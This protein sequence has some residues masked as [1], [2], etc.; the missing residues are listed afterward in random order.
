M[1]LTEKYL[2]IIALV[3]AVLIAF[4]GINPDALRILITTVSI[5]EIKAYI[6]SFGIFAPIVFILLQILQ[7]VVAP[8]PGAI[9]VIAGGLIWGTILG[10]LLSIIGAFTG[11][12]I[13][14]A[15]SRILGRP[16]IEKIMRKEDIQFVDNFF[17]RYGFL[18]ILVL[19]LIP[20]LPFDAISYCLGLTKVDI[21]KFATATLIGMIPGTFLYS[22]IGFALVEE[23]ALVF[24][25]AV[26][27]LIIFISVGLLRKMLR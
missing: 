5:S 3:L 21:R 12:V 15:L 6:G 7:A 11:S 25:A 17:Q 14:F 26:I 9:L 16:F 27:I 23:S 8:I 24:F 20:L 13:C 1:D 4:F 18:A 10:G 2:T 19:R 22:Y